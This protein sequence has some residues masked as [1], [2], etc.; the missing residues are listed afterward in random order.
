MPGKAQRQ[1]IRLTERL[2]RTG[3]RK[4]LAID[5]GGIRGVL[6]LQILARIES[7]EREFEF[8]LPARRLL[9]LCRW[10]QHLSDYHCTHLVGHV[11]R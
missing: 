8:Q 11:R 3:P 4:L 10:D 2:E 1:K 5:G 7:E 6:A 9:R